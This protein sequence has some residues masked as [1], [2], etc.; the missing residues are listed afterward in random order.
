MKTILH[1]EKLNKV[2]QLGSL[3]HRIEINAL[4]DV[5]LLVRAMSRSSSAW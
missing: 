5:N 4:D 1:T 2:Y 3:M